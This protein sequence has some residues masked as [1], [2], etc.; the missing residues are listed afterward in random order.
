MVVGS[1]P[2][3]K[4]CSPPRPVTGIVLPL[5]VCKGEER[6][7]LKFKALYIVSGITENNV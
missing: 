7:K 3:S 4:P 6:D 2:S 1:P 5:P